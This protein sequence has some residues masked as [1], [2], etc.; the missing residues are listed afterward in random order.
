[1]ASIS[2]RTFL[3]RGGTG[4]AA[5]GFLAAIPAFPARAW[6]SARR[7]ATVHSDGV[8]APAGR[9]ATRPL[10][11]HIPDP[12]TGEVHLMVGT[13]EVVRQDSGPRRTPR[14][15]GRLSRATARPPATPIRR[16]ASSYP[17]FDP[18]DK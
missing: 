13:R 10:V 18:D 9:A 6:A 12:R 15:R 4:V 1:M 2:R 3:K 5:A 17:E 14:A 16:A 7:P 11:V 8:A